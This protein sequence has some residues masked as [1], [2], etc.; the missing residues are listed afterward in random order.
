MKCTTRSPL[1]ENHSYGLSRKIAR[2]SPSATHGVDGHCSGFRSCLKL[3]RPPPIPL[4]VKC[5]WWVW[6]EHARTRQWIDLD[7][8]RFFTRSPACVGW[9]FRA[10]FTLLLYDPPCK[11]C[12]TA[13]YQSMPLLAGWPSPQ[14]W[15]FLWFLTFFPS[16]P[17]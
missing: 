3:V 4:P 10:D 11:Q 12:C 5:K 7:G 1:Q 2:K 6:Q 14:Q 13:K 9:L 17:G 16:I 15:T 8:F